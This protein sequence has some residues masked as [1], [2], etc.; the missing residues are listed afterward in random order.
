MSD[1]GVL[2]RQDEPAG[3]VGETEVERGAKSA[4]DSS[5]TRLAKSQFV[6][7]FHGI[8]DVPAGITAAERPYWISKTLFR[9]IIDLVR[10][11][12]FEREVVLTFDDGNITDL[13]AAS[14]LA[15]AGLKGHFFL[16]A[17][18]LGAPNYLDR[19][20]AKEIA[21]AGMEVGLHGHSHVDWRR[22][23]SLDWEWEVAEARATL[24][25]AIDSD[26]T[27]VSIPFG[28]YNRR[29]LRY[30]YHSG[31]ERIY[32][33]DPGPTPPGARVI[34]RTPVMQYSTVED[35][36]AKIEDKCGFFSR[37]RREVVPFIK[38]W[39]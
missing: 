22:N 14:E 31:F 26:V 7:M 20:A 13:F 32:S 36:I 5:E 11:R 39:R 34:R 37:V 4:I 19:V 30:L 25:E 21:R 35:V 16:L 10:S 6:L 15:Q 18:R 3:S 17:G 28:Y 9:E 8:G 23:R 29:V 1:F 12:Q 33:S 38:R 24:A 2:S 27:S